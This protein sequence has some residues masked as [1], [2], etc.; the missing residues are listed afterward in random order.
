[1]CGGGAGVAK[2]RFAPKKLADKHNA[3]DKARDKTFLKQFLNI[4]IPPN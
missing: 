4:K 3:D 1:M 2:A